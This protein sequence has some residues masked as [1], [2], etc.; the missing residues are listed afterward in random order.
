MD[1]KTVAF[2]V[3]PG[4]QRFELDLTGNETGA[5]IAPLIYEK[6]GQQPTPQRPGVKLMWR[7]MQLDFMY[8]P[9]RSLVDSLGRAWDNWRTNDE[10]IVVMWRVL[11]AMRNNSGGGKKTR[12]NRKAL[13][14]SR[15]SR[16]SRSSRR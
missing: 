5:E 2:K 13:K 14:K 16:K 10:T 12:R 7:G 3:F 9:G 8:T 1:T 6:L 15:K 11:S 4:R